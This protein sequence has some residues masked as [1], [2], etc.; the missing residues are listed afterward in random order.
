MTV[1]LVRT[2]TVKL[3]KLKEHDAWG[4]KLVTL[5]KKKPE[6]F[7]GV[8]SMRVLSH[9]KSGN[10]SEFAAIWGFENIDIIKGWENNFSEI[11]EEKA[12][13]VEFMNLIVPNSFS[14]HTWEPVKT[15]KRKIKTKHFKK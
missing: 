15:L 8:K 12:L 14:A 7:K 9:K 2:Y 4:K 6:L 11:P 1:F 10:I 3:D 5:M 13:R